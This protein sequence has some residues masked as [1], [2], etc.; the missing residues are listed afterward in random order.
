MR[1]FSTSSLCSEKLAASPVAVL[2]RTPA[3]R[4][5][6]SMSLLPSRA[7][8]GP[9]TVQFC[10]GHRKTWNSGTEI[11]QTHS[12]VLAT[13]LT[14]AE[15]HA[16]VACLSLVDMQF[17]RRVIQ[18]TKRMESF[19]SSQC[20]RIAHL[21]LIGFMQTNHFGENATL[22]LPESP[23]LGK[24][25]THQLLIQLVLLGILCF[26]CVAFPLLPHHKSMIRNPNLQAVE[27][28]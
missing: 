1:F 3:G 17:A 10:K 15:R 19:K 20:L 23:K 4:F 9:F 24:Q 7:D 6:G 18:V 28:F 8:L 12:N 22:L 27:C 2:I 14:N 16:K 25:S 5:T 13:G 26:Q 11:D 21:D